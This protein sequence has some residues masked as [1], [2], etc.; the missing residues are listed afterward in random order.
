MR[1]IVRALVIVLAAVV[2]A[3]AWAQ[4]GGVHAVRYIMGTWCDLV[5]FDPDPDPEVAAVGVSRDRTSRRRPEQLESR[6]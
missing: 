5:I 1:A 3:P 6:E 4:A 2:A